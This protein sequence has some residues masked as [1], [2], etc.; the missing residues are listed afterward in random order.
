MLPSADLVN[1][2]LQDFIF[3]DLKLILEIHTF[4]NKF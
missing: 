3:Q 4:P 1:A 2:F